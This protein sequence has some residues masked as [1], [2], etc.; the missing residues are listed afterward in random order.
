M[1]NQTFSLE[2]GEQTFTFNITAEDYSS[3]INKFS[4]KN[5]I[6]PAHNFC[7][8]TVAQE[9]KPALKKLLS[10]PSVAPQIAGA[11][12]ESYVPQLNITVKPLKLSKNS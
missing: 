3:F 11:L 2:V 7:M 10:H 1:S 4:E 6:A 12:M 8:Q 5:K 9:D